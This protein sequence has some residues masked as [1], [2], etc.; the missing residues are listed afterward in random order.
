MVFWQPV[1]YFRELDN[2]E[3]AYYCHEVFH[4][5]DNAKSHGY[6]VADKMAEDMDSH[7]VTKRVIFDDKPA[8]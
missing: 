6:D 8:K 2:G 4:D 1:V 5:P 7:V 3:K